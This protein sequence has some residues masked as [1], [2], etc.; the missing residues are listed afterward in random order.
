MQTQ[1]SKTNSSASAVAIKFLSAVQQRDRETVISLFHPDVQWSQ[2]GNNRLS[3]PKNS[4]TEVMQMG[5]DMATIAEQTLVLSHFDI[6]A[7]NDKS[8]VCLLHWVADTPAGKKLDVDNID[9]YEV[10]DGQIVRSLVFT[11]DQ[12][13]E[14]EFWA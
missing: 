8:V 12:A 5:T 4:V 13:Q 3:G 7:E 1:I 2:P 6:L 14:D 10:V 11:A 9:I